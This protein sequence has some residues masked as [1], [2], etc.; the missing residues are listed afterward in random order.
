MVS[1]GGLPH[2]HAG[3]IHFWSADDVAHIQ[4]SIN[5]NAVGYYNFKVSLSQFRPEVT[6]PISFVGPDLGLGITVGSYVANADY[7]ML[8]ELTS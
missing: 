7:Y 8:L 6:I 4:G 2:D 5:K 3:S 1:G